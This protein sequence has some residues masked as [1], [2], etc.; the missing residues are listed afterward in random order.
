LEE[1]LKKKEEDIKQKKEEDIKQKK[2]ENNT[3]NT[4]IFKT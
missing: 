3:F 4:I 1:H 2:E